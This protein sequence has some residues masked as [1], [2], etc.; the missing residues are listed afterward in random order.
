MRSLMCLMAALS[1]SLL[2]LF[3]CLIQ[4]HIS[5]ASSESVFPK[6][7]L[8]TKS[9]Y[10]P[11]GSWSNSAIFY[12]FYEA[13][14]STSPLS[15]TPL[16]I[17][18][19]GGPGCSSMIGN[20]LELGP[21]RIV[22]PR[23]PNMSHHLLQR[24]S[25][26]W[27]RIFGLVFLDNPIGVGFSVASNPEVI[28]R[29]QHSVA[30]HLFAAITGFID[31]DPN[32]KNRPLYITGES[33][34]GK[35]VPAIGFHI[36][37]KNKVLPVSKQVNLKGVAIGNGLTDPV[38]QVKVHADNLYYSGFINEKQKF[39]LEAAQWK[40]VKLIEMG[41]WSEATDARREVLHKIETMTGLATLL[42]Y[43]RMVPY[44]TDFVTKFLRSEEIKKAIGA[45]ASIDFESCSDAVGAA[46]SA[47]VMKS[48]KYMVEFLVK[49]TKVLLYQG[50]HDLQDGV[51]STEAWVR[52][53]RWEG[54]GKFLLADRKIWKVNG[55]LAGYVQKW[56]S[57]SH[58]I[59]LGAG[60]LVPT[61]QS[62]HSQAMIEDWVLEKGMFANKEEGDTAR[63]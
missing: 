36:L 9:G 56:R 30:K 47:D 39:E 1:S 40:V 42:D 62:L 48:V 44:G 32:F 22:E 28:P 24:N 34:G 14:N 7:A 60:H 55:L 26:S 57:L 21:Y 3:L 5:F 25:G 45:N 43:T 17:W 49:E 63:L 18:L 37:M 6:E 52:T 50:H 31:S 20:F 23:K 13:Q 54:I 58:A 11:V 59:V 12:T 33:Y 29:D 16:L 38:T 51:V 2:L 41:L 8:P 27:N 61:D 4:D 53:M 15:E 19:Q 35:Y 10:L 46:L